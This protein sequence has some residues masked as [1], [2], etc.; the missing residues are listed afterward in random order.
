MNSI[1]LEA[2]FAT[3]NSKIIKSMI[4]VELHFKK[5]RLCALPLSK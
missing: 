1:V 5:F 2:Y 3:I 4:V